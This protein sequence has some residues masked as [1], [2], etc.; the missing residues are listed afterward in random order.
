M[1]VPVDVG[2]CPC[3]GQRVEAP[4]LGMVMEVAGVGTIEASILEAVW[5]GRGR[6]VPTQRIFDAM[7]ADDPNGG[8]S[9]TEMYKRFKF[10]LHRL[11]QKL[12]GTGISVENVGYQRGYRLVM[13]GQK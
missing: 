3:C 5:R 6:S 13:E 11:R 12:I 2:A 1:R 9:Q 8:P 7:Y 4:T 10:G